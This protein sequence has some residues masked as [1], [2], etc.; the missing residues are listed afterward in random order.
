VTIKIRWTIESII[1]ITAKETGV[2]VRELVGP[3]RTER[4]SSA[5]NFA[6]YLGWNLTDLTL[7]EI[8]EALGG[9]SPATVSH[10]YQKIAE[11]IG[12]NAKLRF[13]VQSIQKGVELG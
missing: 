6:F 8:G 1:R 13:K 10:G 9:R 4:I 7:A 12:I 5:R 11:R 2:P 3:R